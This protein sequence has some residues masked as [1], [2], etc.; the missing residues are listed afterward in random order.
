MSTIFVFSIAMMGLG[1]AT[2]TASQFDVL[3]KKLV[4]LEKEI[5]ELND[6]IKKSEN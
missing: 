2:Y 5:K 4:Q 3:K 1:L 6:I